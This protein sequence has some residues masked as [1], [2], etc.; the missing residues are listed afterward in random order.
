MSKSIEDVTA[1]IECMLLS[2]HQRKHNRNLTQRNNGIIE[3]NTNDG[4]LAQ[5]KFLTKTLDELTKQ[6]S[7]LLQQLKKIHDVPQ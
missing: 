4:I 5:N 3:L 2:D 1:I 6:M 7:K